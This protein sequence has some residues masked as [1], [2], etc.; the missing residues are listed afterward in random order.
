V[1]T[2]TDVVDSLAGLR[3]ELLR[4]RR[5]IVEVSHTPTLELRTCDACPDPARIAVTGGSYGGYLTLAVLAFSPGPLH[6]RGGHLR[7]V[8]LHTFYATPS[9]GSPPPLTASTV[10]PRRTTC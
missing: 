6:C 8:G 3:A 7:D 9:R 2:N 4:L 1:E 10:T 5:R